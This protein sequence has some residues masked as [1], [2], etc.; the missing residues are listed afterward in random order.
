MDAIAKGRVARTREILDASEI[1]PEQ[2]ECY[3]DLLTIASATAN[4]DGKQISAEERYKATASTMLA[5]A[6][7]IVRSSISTPIM[8]R[9]GVDECIQK[10]I[11]NCPANKKTTPVFEWTA[12][13]PLPAGKLS[14]KFATAI[15][16]IAVAIMG[17]WGTSRYFE[18][19]INTADVTIAKTLASKTEQVANTLAVKTAST[20]SDQ[21]TEQAKVESRI[22]LAVLQALSAKAEKN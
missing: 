4:G 6:N 7:M 20:V 5:L 12:H 13:G 16:V 2:K 3:H 10:H 22:A 19:K 14:G 21:A 17:I 18:Y 8:I 9:E 11:V 1:P 15:G